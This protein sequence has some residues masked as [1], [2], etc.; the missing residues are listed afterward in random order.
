PPTKV[1]VAGSGGDDESDFFDDQVIEEDSILEE[2]L[3]AGFEQEWLSW[4]YRSQD[5]SLIDFSNIHYYDGR[6]ATFPSPTD[7]RPDLGI[8]YK[9]VDGQFDHGKGRTNPIEADAMIAEVV[10]RLD[11]PATSEL[12]Y[13]FVTLNKEQRTLIENKLAKHPHPRL[14]ELFE[15]EDPEQR[16]FVLN[17][18]EVQGRERDV[19][20][21]GTSFSKRRGEGTL[22]LNFGP[23]TNS[24]GERRLNVAV[25]RARK[26]V[27]VVS[28]FDP[29]D[30]R[31]PKSLGLIHLKE[32]LARAA[33]Q[34]S[35]VENRKTDD[36]NHQHSDR[37]HIRE[38]CLRLEDK[39]IEVEVLRGLSQFRVDL[40]LRL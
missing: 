2:A 26:Q 20:V 38:I 3:A 27:V 4:H 15:E 9:R 22:P 39:G 1:A 32:Y 31:E 34:A 40:A 21:M 33:R 11:E 35:D 12:T 13:G 16:I 37:D 28:S 24:G 36:D 8:F 19:I 14:R 17:L 6:L 30:M 10:A 18:E 29:E 7:N 5:E 23:L 25:T